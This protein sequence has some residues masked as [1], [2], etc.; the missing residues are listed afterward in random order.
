MNKTHSQYNLQSQTEIS[1]IEKGKMIDINIIR[2][3]R[4]PEFDQR[5]FLRSKQLVPG[6]FDVICARG[7]QAYNHEG[8]SSIEINDDPI[9]LGSGRTTTKSLS[10]Q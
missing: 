1:F 5:S 7:K 10:H 3:M 4:R 8:V 9:L 6:P 2:S